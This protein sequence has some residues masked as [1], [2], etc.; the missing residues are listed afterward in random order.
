MKRIPSYRKSIVKV[1]ALLAK[2]AS[3]AALLDALHAM[4]ILET[5]ACSESAPNQQSLRSLRSLRE[6]ET[7][8]TPREENP[9][10]G[11]PRTPREENPQ[12]GTPRTPRERNQPPSLTELVL[13]HLRS[14]HGHARVRP[15]LALGELFDLRVARYAP[16]QTRSIAALQ[17]ARRFLCGHLGEARAVETIT[18]AEVARALDA[19]SDAQSWNSVFRRLRLVFNWA[20]QTGLVE[21]SP[22][23]RLAPRRIDWREPAH[24]L[25]DRVERIF[26]AAEA[27]PGPLAGAVGMQLSLGFFAG[28]RTAEIVRARW[29]D[30][31]L[32]G[33]LLRV[34]RPKGFTSGH[35]PRLVELEPCAVAWMRHWRDWLLAAGGRAAGPIVP[36]PRRFA[37]WKRARLDPAGDSW[38]ND[39]AHNVMRH[40]YATMHVAAFRDAGAT[41]LNLGHAGGTELLE[42]H[43]RGIV[44]KA[45]ADAYWRILPSGGPLPPPE[46]EPGRGFRSDLKCPR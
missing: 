40:T 13:A 11:T 14:E 8:R 38:G 28:V 25:P 39:A 29:E 20:V 24:F 23:G 19:F 4:A 43:Y 2:Y 6:N 1:D 7:P 35:K 34:P 45:V 31:D 41:A 46:P 17:C 18:E 30:L 21:R 22:L 10:D 36:H 15:P 27:H 9:Q 42:K 37:L 32:D 26:R 3:S 12:D 5:P 33:A 16:T 44:S